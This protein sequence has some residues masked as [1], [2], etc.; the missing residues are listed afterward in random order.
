MSARPHA[1]VGSLALIGIAVA[2]M[3]VAM[4]LRED[5]AMTAGAMAG[6]VA[7]GLALAAMAGL[8]YV[9]LLRN[10]PRRHAGFS[11]WRRGRAAV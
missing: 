5:P 9:P 10:H 2:G 4:F 11:G 8:L 7:L 6:M 3:A 1:T